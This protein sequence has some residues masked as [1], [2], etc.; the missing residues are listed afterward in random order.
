MASS[1]L[2]LK[3]VEGPATYIRARYEC[4][5]RKTITLKGEHSTKRKSS[6]PKI[7]VRR[8]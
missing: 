6:F 1:T 5:N 7:Q 8:L 3:I 4:E 2:R